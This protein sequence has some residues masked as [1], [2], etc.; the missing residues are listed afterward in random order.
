M[1]PIGTG[2]RHPKQW[3]ADLRAA[4]LRGERI[5]LVK[6]QMWR[7][8]LGYRADAPLDDVRKDVRGLQ[9][10]CRVA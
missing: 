9:Y 2:A 1:T 3:A 10:S 8:A 5:S 6:R 4:E 7:E